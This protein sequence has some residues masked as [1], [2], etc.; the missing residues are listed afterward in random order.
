MKFGLA[1]ADLSRYLK[2]LMARGNLPKDAE[3]LLDVVLLDL[4]YEDFEQCLK[5]LEVKGNL[6]E[7]YAFTV[8]F[9]KA[10][11]P[12][13]YHKLA[14]GNHED[15][16]LQTA[17][18][19]LPALKDNINEL[20]LFLSLPTAGIKPKN[21][22]LGFQLIKNSTDNRNLQDLFNQTEHIQSNF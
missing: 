5:D 22:H 21:V 2:K 16:D 14:F 7:D 15:Q 13:E 11:L 6:A 19:S 12:V 10:G 3:L 9:L 4:T 20:K 8:K 1:P 17:F 18:N